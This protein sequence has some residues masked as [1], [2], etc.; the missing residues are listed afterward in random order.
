LFFPSQAAYE[1]SIPFA[2]S[3]IRSGLT[4]QLRQTAAYLSPPIARTVLMSQDDGAET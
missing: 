3:N 4:D 2:R 1:G